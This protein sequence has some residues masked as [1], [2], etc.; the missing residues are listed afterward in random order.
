MIQNN[1]S[2]YDRVSIEDDIFYWPSVVFTNF[3]NPRSEFSRQEEYLETHIAR[4]VTLGVNSK[5][6]YGVRIQK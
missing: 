3:Y 1:V 2:I 4:G 6:V 5:I